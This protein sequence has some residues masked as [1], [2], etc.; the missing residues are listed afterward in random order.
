MTEGQREANPNRLSA[1]SFGFPMYII[2]S[3]ANSDSFIS[4][5]SIFIPFIYLSCLITLAK[6]S[7]QC[8]TE[9][10]FSGHPC[11]FLI[12]RGKAFNILLLNV[13]NIYCICLQILFIRLRAFPPVL[14]MQELLLLIP[15]LKNVP[16]EIILPLFSPLI[17]LMCQIILISKC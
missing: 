15:F 2:L 9:V 4:M 17:L 12:P 16:I 11:L 8:C 10:V 14:N 5:F 6:T 13:C 3:S 7:K 1:A